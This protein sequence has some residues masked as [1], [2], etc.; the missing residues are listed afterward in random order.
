MEHLSGIQNALLN[1]IKQSL[2]N[3]KAQIDVCDWEELETLAR[4]QG[5]LTML[6]PGA[7]KC[8][9]LIPADV[10]KHW[11]RAMYSAVLRNEQ[12]NEIQQGILC[13]M[14]ENNIRVCVLKGLSCSRYY[15]HT[16]IRALGDIDLLVNKSDLPVIDQFLR[17]LGY[18]VSTEEHQFHIGYQNEDVVIEIHYG[19]TEF[20]NSAAGKIISDITDRFLD[21]IQ[22]VTTSKWTFPSLSEKDHA[23]T[24]LLH[25]ERHLVERGIGLRQLADWATFFA[26]LE[27]TDWI[28]EFLLILDACGLLTFAKV[29]T[30][31]CVNYL[32]LVAHCVDW[33]LEA[34]EELVDALICDVFRTGNVGMADTAGVG[35]IFGSRKL[36]GKGNQTRIAGLLGRLTKITHKNYPFTK[37]YKV[38]LPIFWLYIPLRYWV[39]SL[40]GLRPKK[41]WIYIVRSSK[42]RKQLQN[43]LNLYKKQ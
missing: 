18:T 34:K 19:I 20:P 21:N 23:L 33:C 35:N 26:N 31:V 22:V 12:L 29:V 16:D 13:W 27:K 32:G 8:R 9:E 36:L 1:L 40:F 3:Q 43:E 39:R 4:N 30:K 38:L 2:W 15:R 10:I 42:H 6:Y 25:M 17:E 41:D 37:K 24:L 14:Q 11:Q 5:V 7:A 28:P